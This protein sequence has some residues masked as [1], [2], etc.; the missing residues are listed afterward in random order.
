M[1][2]LVSFALAVAA[3][4]IIG[5]QLIWAGQTHVGK[6]FPDWTGHPSRVDRLVALLW[7]P[8]VML[9]IIGWLIE[10]LCKQGRCA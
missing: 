10:W 5:A 6:Q 3:I 9:I 7:L 1:I 2:W 8:F 4:W